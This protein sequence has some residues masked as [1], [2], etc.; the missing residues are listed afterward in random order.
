MKLTLEEYLSKHKQWSLHTFGTGERT[1]GILKHLHK[2]LEE[3]S[4]NPT[5]LFEWID[6]I[7]LALDGY[8]RH[9]GDTENILKYLEIKQTK[10][11]NRSW[12]IPV[13]EDDPIE[14]DRTKD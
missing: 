1:T 13:C 11:F 10:N 2:E 6:V 7:I 14:H 12:V 5:D 4:K 9:G 8:W 3:I